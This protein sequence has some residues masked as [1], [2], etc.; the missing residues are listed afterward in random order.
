M[1]NDD[2]EVVGTMVSIIPASCEQTG[3]SCDKH[4]DSWEAV[5]R[6]RIGTLADEETKA[7]EDRG[8]DG[9]ESIE[10]GKE[11]V[12][13]HLRTLNAGQEIKFVTRIRAEH[14]RLLEMPEALRGLTAMH[15]L[16]IASSKLE[17]LP[18]WLGEL[19]GLKV[20]DLEGVHPKSVHSHLAHICRHTHTYTQAPTLSSSL[21]LSLSH[22][23][24]N[25]QTHTYTQIHTHTCTP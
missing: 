16:T 23:H 7:A 18:E 13:V 9:M 15:E 8:E 21:A 19:D 20:L 12:E 25:T 2:G 3:E 22:T 10:M 6:Q 17:T 1:E 4:G 11:E 24:T 14:A 5:K